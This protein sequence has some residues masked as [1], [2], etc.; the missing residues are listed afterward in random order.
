MLFDLLDL[1]LC[2][3][4]SVW[5]KRFWSFNFEFQGVLRRTRWGWGGF[6]TRPRGGVGG[7]GGGVSKHF[8][9]TK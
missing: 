6:R 3:L 7:S 2:K 1:A 5:V 9:E 4:V 8:M